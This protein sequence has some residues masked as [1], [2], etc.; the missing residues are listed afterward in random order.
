MLRKI[1][2]REIA[3]TLSI[4]Q[5]IYKFPIDSAP[6]PQSQ[7]TDTDNI[8]ASVYIVELINDED[9]TISL[10]LPFEVPDS[11]SLN[12]ALLEIGNGVDE[13]KVLYT[14]ISALINEGC[15]WIEE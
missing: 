13:G 2:N 9:D 11:T 5:P 6:L 3:T 12:K 8:A 1:T 7:L 10:E 14:K 4:G 15:W